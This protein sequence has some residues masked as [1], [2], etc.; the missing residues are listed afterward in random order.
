VVYATL[1]TKPEKIFVGRLHRKGLY[2]GGGWYHFSRQGVAYL[3]GDGLNHG[4][5]SP[6]SCHWLLV[7]GGIVAVT[8]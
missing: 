2:R 1:L 5:W 7:T 8:T 6:A 3:R 4:Y